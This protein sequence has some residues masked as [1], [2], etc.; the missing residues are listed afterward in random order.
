MFGAMPSAAAA[1]SVTFVAQVALDDGLVERLGLSRRLIASA[2]TRSR[3]KVD[4]P[5][6]DAMPSI[7]VH[8]DTFAVHI[9]GE[10]IDEQPVAE[11]PMAQRYFLF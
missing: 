3:G 11:L 10:L 9:D 5:E 2:D 6:N 8:P 1:T 4:L 7:T